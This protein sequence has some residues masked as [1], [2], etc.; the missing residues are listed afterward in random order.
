MR[1]AFKIDSRHGYLTH[2]AAEWHPLNKRWYFFPRKVSF[3]PF[4]QAVDERE[5]GSN[6]L[7]IADETFQDIQVQTI[8]ERIS[9]RGVSSFKFIPGHPEE[10]VALKTVERDGMTKTYAFCFDLQG[11]VLSNEI[12]LGGY[13]CEGV[14]MI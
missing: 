1:Q 7:I 4:D 9:D 14:E 12:F 13:K 2:E 5:R 11:N 3:A 6:T 10:V 8:G